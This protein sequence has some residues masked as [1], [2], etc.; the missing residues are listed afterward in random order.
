[1]FRKTLMLC[2]S[3]AIVGCGNTQE[4]EFRDGLPSKEMVTVK[5]PGTSAGQKLE[6]EGGAVFA[7]DKGQT[8]D[9]YK[10]TRG[11]TVSV[12]LGTAFVLNLI[13]EVTKHTPTSIEGDVAV[14]GPYT[15]ALSP[16]TFKVTVTK[17]AENAYSYK[18]EGKAKTAADTEFKTIIS[19]SHTIATDELGNRL[20]NYGSGNIQLDWDAA[21]TLPEHG[22]ELGTAAIRYSRPDAK[23]QATVEAD[24]RNVEDDERPGTRVNADYRYKET[25]GA[26]G[27]FE[28]GLDKNFDT[29]PARSK[30]EH[31]TIKSRW[32]QTGAGRAD[33]KIS[34]GDY[35]IASA[36]ASECWD[37]NFASQFLIAS[38]VTA[39]VYGDVSA[40]GSFSVALYSSL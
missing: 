16:N 36:T 12:N 8:S 30:I 17:T 25:P 26:G 4:D 40:C 29:E 27:E 23:A 15:D 13:E 37:A 3:L 34:G 33:V 6:A 18:V 2:A 7:F 39:P 21:Q 10:L 14:W 28:F 22:D 35:L 19:G 31:L 9:F 24:F 5:E 32:A 20:R 1:M 11:A 38:W